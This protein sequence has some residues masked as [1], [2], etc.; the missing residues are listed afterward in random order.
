MVAFHRNEQH[1]EHPSPLGLGLAVQVEGL[2]RCS[3]R[4]RNRLAAAF[5][6]AAWAAPAVG[7]AHQRL[8]QVPGILE[9]TLPQQSR[10][11]AGHAVGRI[12]GQRVVGHHHA[13]RRG[14]AGLRVPLRAAVLAA[15]VPVDHAGQ[16]FWRIS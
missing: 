15:V 14:D 6:A 12:G 16:G 11:F 13:A 10:A 5:R 8:Q 2:R 7:P 9:V 1:A 4:R 3:H